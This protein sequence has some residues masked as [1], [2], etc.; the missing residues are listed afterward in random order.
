MHTDDALIEQAAVEAAA[1]AA[2]LDRDGYV[3]LMLY[4]YGESLSAVAWGMPDLDPPLG[5][6][7]DTMTELGMLDAEGPAISAL[8][9]RL[10]GEDGWELQERFYLA[11]AAHVHARIGQ[12]VLVYESA[13]MAEEEQLAR[14]GGRGAEPA[15][16][17]LA[18]LD[19]IVS[20]R[21]D[22]HRVAAIWRDEEGHVH[23]SG[24][25]GR[26]REDWTVSRCID[27]GSNPVV[28][29]G[30]LPPGAVRPAGLDGELVTGGGYW[31]CRTGKRLLRREPEVTSYEDVEGKPF[32]HRV[33]F[34]GVPDLWPRQAPPHE[35]ADQDEWRIHVE[36]WGL[37]APAAGEVAQELG[38]DEPKVPV[39]P[40]TG[41]V[42]GHRH[43]FELA[44]QDG[45]WAATAEC[46][47]FAI[48]MIGRGAP[49]E[50][51]DFDLVPGARG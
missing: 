20:L 24:S 48:T 14:Q 25:V 19:V 18:G 23:A 44:A 47:G 12:P 22:E 35:Q 6:D 28:L 34:D 9:E 40:I 10:D 41:T 33:P 1:G 4:T 45:V 21:I 26:D 49:P 32:A 11:L 37:F 39:R 50:R 8:R 15:G 29:A 13:L 31:L 42:L 27:I 3:G 46:G 17:P 36:D 2:E 51:L 30:Q 5:I 38:V 16:S 43:G 7:G